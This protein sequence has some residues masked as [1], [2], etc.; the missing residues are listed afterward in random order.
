PKTTTMKIRKFQV[1]ERLEQGAG[2]GV[3]PQASD[4]PT[5]GVARVTGHPAGDVREDSYLVSD[6][7]LT[8]I[9][10][11]ELVTFLEQSYRLDLE[12]SLIGPQTRVRDL[13][14]MV[15]RREKVSARSRIRGWTGSAPVRVFRRLADLLLH[16]PLFGAFVRLEVTGLENLQGVSQ[17]VFFISNHLSYLD[18]PALMFALPPGW[19]YN[20]ATAAWEEFFFANYRNL[21][22]KI[23]KRAAYEYATV[24]FNVF[25]LPQSSGFRRSLRHMGKVIDGGMNVL[26]FPEGER[27]RDGRMLP[28]RPGL[29]LMV[30]ELGVPVVPLA[31]AGLEEV[32][33]P[34]AVVPKPGRVAVAVG[35]PLSFRLETPEEIIERCRSEVDALRENAITRREL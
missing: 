14:E 9:A 8:S 34:G 25:P 10:R 15:S 24:A 16:Y 4:P 13:R 33:P 19:R 11:L 27:S 17:P 28:F 1:R 30:K 23:W 3:A 20:T 32:F 26:L 31:I 12:E 2:E 6:L 29:G 21:P 18:H 35:K 7:G 22:Q 5:E